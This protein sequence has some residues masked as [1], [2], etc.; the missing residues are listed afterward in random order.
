MFKIYDASGDVFAQC[1]PGCRISSN[2]I[3]DNSDDLLENVVG[4]GYAV[5]WNGKV[6]HPAD[7]DWHDLPLLRAEFEE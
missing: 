6:Y 2:H 3:G 7:T 5:E 1:E 4:Q